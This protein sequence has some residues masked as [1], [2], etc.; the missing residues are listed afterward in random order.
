[1]VAIVAFP[2]LAQTEAYL[3]V[4][5]AIVGFRFNPSKEIFEVVRFTTEGKRYVLKG[6][7]DLWIWSTM[8]QND[9][10]PCDKFS[11]NETIQCRGIEMY[12]FSKRTLR[13]QASLTVGFTILER[14]S[15]YAND[16]P[17]LEMGKCSR[18]Q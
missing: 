14:S 15:E 17:Y 16:N 7:G 3:C 1:M 9:A 13:Y 5:D 2:V 18:L 8:G 12:L 6:V 10:K 11:E 4:P